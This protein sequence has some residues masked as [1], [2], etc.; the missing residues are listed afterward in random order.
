ME[1][2]VSEFAMGSLKDIFDFYVETAG[3]AIARKI[4]NRLFN[5]ATQLD[6]AGYLGTKEP[7]LAHKKIDYRF[8]LLDPHKI[9][10]YH[11]KDTIFIV[12][13]FDTRQDPKKL[14]RRI[15]P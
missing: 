3:I 15:K 11:T 6:S 8:Y 7:L 1:V 2:V 9:I 4:T 5:Q 13:F 14:K 10:F 12:D